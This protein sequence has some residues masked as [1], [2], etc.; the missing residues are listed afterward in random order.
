[1]NVEEFVRES[2]KIEG[3]LRDPTSLEVEATADFVCRKQISILDLC[4]LVDIYQPGAKL[5][6]LPG[7]DVRVGADIPPRGGVLI[8]QYLNNLLLKLNNRD[9]SPWRGH[10][11]YLHIHPFT[12]GNGRTGRALWL[13]SIGGDTRNG[14][15]HQFY[16]ETLQHVKGHYG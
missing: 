2:N 10:I 4:E 6:D 12:D 11:E 15:L 1:M 14:F 5:R 8:P 3:I 9:I 7:L 13:W 16:Y